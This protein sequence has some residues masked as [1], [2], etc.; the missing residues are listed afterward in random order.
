MGA[1][2]A[3]V[4]ANHGRIHRGSHAVGQAMYTT[5]LVATSEVIH[6][7]ARHGA[8]LWPC[9]NDNVFDTILKSCSNRHTIPTSN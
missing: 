3:T 8:L 2:Y 4:A 9:L 7:I 1:P 5:S 6:P